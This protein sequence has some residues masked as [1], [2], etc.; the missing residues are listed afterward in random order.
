M[1]LKLPCIFIQFYD[2]AFQKI[3]A[4]SW[5]CLTNFGVLPFTSTTNSFPMFSG[6]AVAAV[7][8]VTFF[9]SGSVH[10]T[11]SIHFPILTFR[12]FKKS[13]TLYTIHS[14][15]FFKVCW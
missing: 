5:E 6:H 14:K 9:K 12:D 13:D 15:P 7:Q 4:S 11:P 10:V 8:H 3:A 1:I 2:D